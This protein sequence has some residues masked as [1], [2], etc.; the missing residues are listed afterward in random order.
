MKPEDLT[1][2]QKELF[3]SRVDKTDDED[4]CWEWQAGRGHFN[5]GMFRVGP[6]T[7]H[8]HR[9]SFILHYNIELYTNE[10]VCH[11]CDNPPRCNPNHLFIGSRKDNMQDMVSKN[12][13]PSGTKNTQHKLTEEQ[14]KDIK[15]RKKYW[16]INTHLASEFNVSFQL[17]K[18]IREGK[19]RAKG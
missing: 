3:W 11:S 7:I 19:R 17:I 10:H 4:E 13:E 6:S 8:T 16:G 15:S 14:V 9:L 18:L 12:R 1:K 5:Y 2:E